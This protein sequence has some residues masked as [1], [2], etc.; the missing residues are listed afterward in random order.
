MNRHWRSL[1]ADGL[2][3]PALTED[4]AKLPEFLAEPCQAGQACCEGTQKEEDKPTRM[5]LFENRHL[6]N[7]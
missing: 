4:F 1:P 2:F 6:P 7:R 5:N 3:T